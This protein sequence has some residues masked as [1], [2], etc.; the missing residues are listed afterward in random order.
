MR[1]NVSEKGKLVPRGIGNRVTRRTTKRNSVNL[2]VKRF[3]IN[4][5]KVKVIL[6]SSCL[7][8]LKKDDMELKKIL[9]EDQAKLINPSV[10]IR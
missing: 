1:K 2:R 9:G 8:R 7:K 4:G 5:S 10:E 3:N 6:C